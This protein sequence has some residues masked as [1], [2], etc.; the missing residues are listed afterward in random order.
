M[1]YMV[2]NPKNAKHWLYFSNESELYFYIPSEDL[3]SIFFN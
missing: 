1:Y 3:S 2:Y